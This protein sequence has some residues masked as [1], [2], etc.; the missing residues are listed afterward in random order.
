MGDHGF[1]GWRE[2]WRDRGKDEEWKRDG[3]MHGEEEERRDGGSRDEW[4]EYWRNRLTE[5]WSNEE[6]EIVRRKVLEE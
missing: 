6:V 3:G 1:E 5:G 2:G 4:M